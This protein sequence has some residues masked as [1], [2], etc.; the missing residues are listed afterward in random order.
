MLEMSRRHPGLFVTGNY[1][2]G[3]SVAACVTQAREAVAQVHRFL[4]AQGNTPITS[5]NTV[6]GR[7]PAASVS[8]FDF[9]KNQ[10]SA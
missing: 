5:E 10:A 9:G 3:P 8:E 4:E 6:R 2:S 1:L 7:Q